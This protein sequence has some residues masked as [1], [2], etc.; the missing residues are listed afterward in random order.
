ML[1][2]DT[3][4]Y[5]RWLGQAKHTLT[6]AQRDT[7]EGDFDWAC[8]KAQQA[9][10]Y[11]LKALFSR[12][13][14]RPAYGHALTRL[15]G[16][17]GEAGLAIKEETARAGQLLDR[18]YIPTRYPDAYAEGSPH[19]YYDDHTAME[20]QHAAAQI[21]DWVENTLIQARKREQEELFAEARAYAARVR[22]H[23]PQARVF[24]YGSVARGDFNLHSDIDLL[25]VANLPGHPLK[26]SEVLYRYVQ[27]REE[28]KG[29]TPA[30]FDKLSVQG[31]LEYLEGAQEL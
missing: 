17:L 12:G 10:Q 15:L 8:F 7:T 29:L 16:Q 13:L 25:V 21:I 24:L 9:G 20:A 23:F 1:P 28:P 2:F 19:E 30:E 5:G 6:S 31:K 11:A 4:E 3:G 22:C 26:R 14:G 18:H 27:G